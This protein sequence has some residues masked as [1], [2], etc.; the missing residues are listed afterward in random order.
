M[1]ESNKPQNV[2]FSEVAKFEALASRWWDRESEF[3]PLHD[4]NPLRLNFIDERAGLAGKKVL[5]V[6]CGGGILSESMAQRGADVSGIDMGE[7]PLSVAKLHQLESGLNINY[8]R[9][10]AEEL[11]D[12]EPEQYDVVTC[13]EMLEHVPEP[14][15]V[16]AACA[17]LVK[18]GG[19]VFFS[20]INRNP[21]AYLFAIVG[22]EY[23]LKML[24][25]GTHDFSKFIRPSELGS[26]TRA[27]GLKNGDLTGMTYNP[28]TKH[29]KL[30]SKDV[31][32]NYL[33]Q[34]FKPAETI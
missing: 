11:A 22:A 4:I 12:Q 30:D 13:L 20:T 1:T 18:P 5:D 6:G 15:K 29:Y 21:K 2:D 14:A 3:K 31:T 9:I 28:L 27:A 33:L 19:Q 16:I 8:R 26:W 25:K 7:A 10:T 34:C 17:R 24:P 32:V 23:L